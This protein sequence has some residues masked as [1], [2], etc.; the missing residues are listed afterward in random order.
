MYTS[1]KR[2]FGNH[3]VV[4]VNDKSVN[5]LIKIIELPNE[6]EPDGI[7]ISPDGKIAVTANEIRFPPGS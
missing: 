1:V 2:C 4:G 6:A 5:K 3:D 7:A